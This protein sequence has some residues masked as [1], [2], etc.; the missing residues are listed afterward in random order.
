MTE[1]NYGQT[2]SRLSGK[3]KAAELVDRDI[4][5]L[6]VFSRMGIPLRL[7]DST[8]EELCR[9]YN[10]DTATFLLVCN[11]YIQEDYLPSD[12]ELSQI[13][14]NGILSY[15]RLSHKYYLSSAISS[16]ASMLETLMEPCGESQRKVIRKFYNE[17]KRELEKHFEYEEANI[18]PLAEALASGKK[19]SGDIFDQ[20]EDDHSNIEE[21]IHDLKSIVT[22][23]LP[24][25]CK[26][27]IITVTLLMIHYLENDLERHTAIEDTVL[28]PMMS[29]ANGE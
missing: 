27:E 17:Y 25:E 1:T 14:M 23:Y 19:L 11:I 22:K 12:Q 29:K 5:I 18:F 6:G 8:I 9:K 3:M 26:E 7:G 24:S 10:V 13:K 16:L 15:L 28:L 21:K 20:L 2:E 4:N